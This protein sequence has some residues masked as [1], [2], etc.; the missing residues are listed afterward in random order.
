MINLINNLE[1]IAKQNTEAPE[2]SLATP[3]TPCEFCGSVDHNGQ[4]CK[5]ERSIV[6]RLKATE[7]KGKPIPA[8]YAHFFTPEAIDRR[9]REWRTNGIG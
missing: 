7:K 9:A 4:G 6:R 1:S 2:V 5:H 8:E 3:K